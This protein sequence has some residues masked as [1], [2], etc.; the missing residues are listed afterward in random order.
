MS[1]LADAL[2][3]AARAALPPVEGEVRAPGLRTPVRVA[4]DRWGVPH[5]TAESLHDLF[6]AQSYVVA[7]DRLF[8]MELIFR[9]STGRLSELF[10]ELTLPID[11]FVRTVGWNR[12]AERHAAQRDDLSDEVAA[13][14]VAGFR[15]WVEAMP[16]PPPEYRVLATDP[17]VPNDEEAAEAGA[18]AGV[19]MAWS[20]SRAWD[21][22]LLRAEIAERHG[23]EMMRTLFPDI[24][25]EPEAV[26]AAKDAGDPRLALLAEAFLPPSGQGS[27]N[28]VVAGSRT[29]SGK[30]LL[31]NDPHLL[32]QSPSVWYEVHLRAPGI[33]VAGVSFPFAPGVVIGHN[34]RIAW[35][36]TN[37]E[38]D[39]QDLYLERLSD[40]GTRCEYRG[41]WEPVTIHR[42]E[43]AV[44]GR[45]E[46]EVVE[47]RETRHGP[48]LTSYMLGIANPEVVEG[49]IRKP[50]AL[51][52]VGLERTIEPS[53]VVRL[54]MAKNWDEFRAALEHWHCPG[55]NAVYADVDGNIGYQLTGLYPRR[56]AG[57]GSLPVPGWT[58]AYEW[59]GWIPFDE[60]PRAFNPESGYLVTANN[61]MY[62]ETY[63][64]HLGSDFLPPY[65]AR[66]VTQLL[67]GTERHTAE[68]FARIQAD[69]VSL[70]ARE[71]CAIL[72]R[73][74][75]ADDR[76]KEALALL[77]DWDHDL[78]AGS[79]PAAVYEV[80]CAH[81]A[82][83]VLRPLLD[84]DLFDHFYARR[85]WTNGFQ[86]RVLPHVLAYPTARWFGRDGV[87]ARDEVL[88]AALDGALDELAGRLGED[89]GEWRWGAIHRARFASRLAIV[90]DLAE[91]FTAG[92]VEVGGDEQTV[93]QA[94]FEPG[95]PYEVVVMPSWRQILDP[96]DW[97]ACLGA[98]TLGQSGNVESPH[99]RD[100]LELWS[101]VRHHAMP[102]TEEA[103]ARETAAELRLLP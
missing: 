90:P 47:V 98:H 11:R 32:V 53:T 16:A 63:P 10:G 79:A 72:A 27:N 42:E 43:I 82:R 33:D 39:V 13:A 97:D 75:P 95:V 50:Y 40:D 73:V 71:I 25:P 48:I 74:E 62:D 9:L 7:S 3:L 76:Q 37:T 12:A 100:Q 41:D 68:T 77:A 44:R 93:N 5:I 2:R 56:R 8:Q 70:P 102:F 84:P 30:P 35:G 99:Y 46:P 24:D 49:G 23:A 103:V 20:L 83:V 61:R 38:A 15:A 29:A 89:M 28:W 18:A 64:H 96:S 36:L 60:L 51:R 57:D 4:R 81:I 69:T 86:Y 59:D 55:Q 45:D 1:E 66:R 58:D 94:L 19:F 91:L 21:N 22:D 67:T 87:E 65:R 78:A 85:Q 17:W 101:A 54:D 6:F 26:R 88:R 34:E 52:W 14:S 80:W 31:A 92:E